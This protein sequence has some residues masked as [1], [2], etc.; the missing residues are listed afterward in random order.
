[1]A[2]VA[3][4]NKGRTYISPTAEHITT[5]WQAVPDWKP[6]ASLPQNQRNFNTPNFGINTYDQIFTSRQLVALT[7]CSDLIQE[8]Q[9]H[10]L[11]D[12]TGANFPADSRP[13]HTGGCGALAYAD[14]VATYLAIAFDKG[15]DYWSALCSWHTGWNIISHMFTRQALPMV[16]FAEANPLSE[17]SG[18][19]TGTAKWVAEVITAVPCDMPGHANQRDAA[20]S[21]NG[22]VQPLVSNDPP[23]YDNIGYADLADFFYI[24]LRRSLARIYPELFRT[25][26]VP[27]KQELVAT[28]YHFEGDKNKAQEV[29]EEDLGH[30]FAHMREAQYLEYPL[31]VYS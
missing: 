25:I 21:V 15:A 7:T 19:V 13:L 31:T 1:M 3:E 2:I 29:F 17:S 26:L 12:A 30:A 18:N 11:A 10:V 16:Y 23:Y 5:A 24:W 20:A 4:G 28:P 9:Q 14:A 8:V 6:E 22:V 27:K